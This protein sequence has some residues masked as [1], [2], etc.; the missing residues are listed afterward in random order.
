M[1]GD[2]GF[3]IVVVAMLSGHPPELTLPTFTTSWRGYR[4][5]RQ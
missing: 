2:A 5:P 4:R 1:T 3:A